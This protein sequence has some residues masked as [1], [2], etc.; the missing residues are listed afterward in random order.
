MATATPRAVTVESEPRPAARGGTYLVFQLAEAEHAAEVSSVR[1]IIGPLPITRVPRMP[2]SVRGVVNLRG[3][4]IPVVDLRL[5]FGLEAVDHGARTC[6][7]VVQS[8]GAELGLVVDRVIEVT[9]IADE[10]IED[11]PSFAAGV[12]TEYLLGIARHGSRV[13]LLLDIERVLPRH[14]LAALAALPHPPRS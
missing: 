12:E 14:E 5:R 4:I 11:V 10:A 13:R 2:A 1:E 7:I 9:A 3:K 8:G 6:I